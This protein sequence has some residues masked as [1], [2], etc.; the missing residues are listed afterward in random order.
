MERASHKF[1]QFHKQLDEIIQEKSYINKKKTSSFQ[2]E[3][4]QNSYSGQLMQSTGKMFS[5]A[6]SYL[7]TSQQE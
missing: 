5:M 1:E 2:D 7:F 6:A 4:Y 3:H